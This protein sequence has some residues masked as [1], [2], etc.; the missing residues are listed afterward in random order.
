MRKLRLGSIG[1]GARA[2]AHFAT[3]NGLRD[4]FEWVA[5]CDVAAERAEAAAAKYGLQAYA[6]LE[7]MLEGERLDLVDVVVPMEGAHIVGARCA[8]HGVHVHTE[9]AI[10]STLPCAD[11][12]N[13]ACERNGGP[14]PVSEQVWP[15][16]FAG[17]KRK[18]ITA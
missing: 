4:R 15:W 10:S 1:A 3:I 18:L 2:Q 17:I 11:Y 8:F 9:T 5:V 7:A 12:P 14:L 13:D 6:D 16:P